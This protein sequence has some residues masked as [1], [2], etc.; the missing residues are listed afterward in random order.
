MVRY[1]DDVVLGFQHKSDANRYRAELQVRLATFG[2]NLHPAK[3]QLICF[4]RFAR[5][6]CQ[7][8]GERKPPTFDFLGF[9]HYCT[10]TRKSGRFMVGRKT[11]KKRLRSQLKEIKQE[12]RRRLHEPIGKT[13]EWLKRVLRGHLNYYAVPGNS[14]S[15]QYLF[16][17]VKRYWL[18]SLRRRSQRHRMNWDRFETLWKRFAPPILIS[19]DHPSNRFDAR[20]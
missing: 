8:R 9:T 3:T 14:K 4:G 16:F 18:C 20:T 6:D 17:R 13:G 2:L 12:L 10:T 11:I 7:L 19:H 1:A 5:R 15:L